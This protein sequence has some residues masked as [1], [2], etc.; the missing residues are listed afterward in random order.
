MASLQA[1]HEESRRKIIISAMVR[2]RK[3]VDVKVL[4]EQAAVRRDI[5]LKSNAVYNDAANNECFKVMLE[6]MGEA[7]AVSEMG[8]GN[9]DVSGNGAAVAKGRGSSAVSAN[10]AAP[11]SNRIAP[12]PPPQQSAY[13]A[14]NVSSS[15]NSNS[16]SIT[17]P[18]NE[19]NNQV[20]MI[21]SSDESEDDINLDNPSI[22]VSP[23]ASNEKQ[24]MIF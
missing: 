2:N 8:S 10:S 17:S 22:G 6:S 13:Y 5:E 16:N 7:A 21:P 14:N 1:A 24:E 20:R 23:T 4:M 9:N 3:A 12:S 15:N 11:I 19:L 18:M